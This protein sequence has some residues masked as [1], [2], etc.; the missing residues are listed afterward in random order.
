MY[1]ILGSMPGS[2]GTVVNKIGF[3]ALKEYYLLIMSIFSP[4]EFT[5]PCVKDVENTSTY[6]RRITVVVIRCSNVGAV[7]L[8]CAGWGEKIE[9]CL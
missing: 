9:I 1:Y 3:S 7:F 2:R 6:S 8:G 4:L 5:F